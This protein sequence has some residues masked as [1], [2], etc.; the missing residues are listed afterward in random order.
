MRTNV[1]Q[2][3]SFHKGKSSYIPLFLEPVKAGFPS[4]AEDFVENALNLNEYLI[5]HPIATF[6]V[7]VSG[8]S[9][10]NAGIQSGDML[11]VDRSLEPLDNNIIVVVL[12]E[13][14]T[15]KRIKKTHN[16]LF[17]VSENEECPSIEI[18]P[19]MNFEVWGVVTYV[20]HKTI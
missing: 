8:D 16:S 4:P 17:L 11:I 6:F 3:Y 9:M 13:E 7:K 18:K 10:V 20:I 12:N 14:M 15:V 1:H 5:H 19:E 2:I